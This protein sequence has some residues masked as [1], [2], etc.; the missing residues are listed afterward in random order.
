MLI[1]SAN[2]PPKPKRGVIIDKIQ[3]L[4]VTP[5]AIHLLS[6]RISLIGKLNI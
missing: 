2:S 3:V 6:V 5:L 4:P 1:V